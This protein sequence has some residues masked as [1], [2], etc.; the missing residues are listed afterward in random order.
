MREQEE[1]AEKLFTSLKL[2][3]P[4]RRENLLHNDLINQS[5]MQDLLDVRFRHIGEIVLSLKH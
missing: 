4:L 5:L 2:R 3:R 1:R